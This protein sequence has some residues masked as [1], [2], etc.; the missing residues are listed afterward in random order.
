MKVYMVPDSYKEF[1]PEPDSNKKVYM[2]PN[3]Y[4]EYLWGLIATRK[5]IWCLMATRNI[6]GA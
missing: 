4:E 5:F 2:M 3:S 6:Y 1:S